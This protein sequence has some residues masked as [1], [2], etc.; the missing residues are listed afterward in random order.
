MRAA[1]PRSWKQSPASPAVHVELLD[2]D[3]CVLGNERF[4]GESNQSIRRFVLGLQLL[5]AAQSEHGQHPGYEPGDRVLGAQAVDG[6]VVAIVDGQ[7]IRFEPWIRKEAQIE[8]VRR[9]ELQV[10]VV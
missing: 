2:A 9:I 6:N 7:R 10:G 4:A 8:R 3:D 5:V 1:P